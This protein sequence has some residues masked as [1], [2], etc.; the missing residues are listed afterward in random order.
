MRL[1]ITAAAPEM[2]ECRTGIEDF[3]RAAGHACLPGPLPVEP[4]ETLIERSLEAMPGCDGLVFLLDQ[5]VDQLLQELRYGGRA[6]WVRELRRACEL[7][8]R[9]VVCA[10]NFIQKQLSGQLIS[11][12]AKELPPGMLWVAFENLGD[13]GP[14]L[15]E[16][17]AKLA[18]SPSGLWLRRVQQGG[19]I[20]L[21]E[22][23]N[24][25]GRMV[26]SVDIV[27]DDAAVSR[28]HA[29]ISLTGTQADI[30]DLQSRGGTYVNSTRLQPGRR[31][32]LAVG[33]SILIGAQM[34]RLETHGFDSA[35]SAV[36][37][38]HAGTDPIEPGDD[39]K[40]D[41]VDPALLSRATEEHTVKVTPPSTVPKEDPTAPVETPA[42]RRMPPSDEKDKPGDL[43]MA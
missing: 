37:S 31:S 1:Y 5:G 7:E 34:L 23:E 17:L 24:V 19:T 10:A 9:V 39:E 6:P 30:E 2:R 12:L 4:S 20:P 13:L 15:G 21:Y 35:T 29:R 11:E 26:G 36:P 43:H 25:L 38:T 16:T 3:L 28:R 27:L 8:R 14:K 41:Q 42:P 32:P 33:D 22:R 18:A 40:T